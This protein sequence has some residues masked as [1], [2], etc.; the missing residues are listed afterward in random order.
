M[1]EY[2]IND[3]ICSPDDDL[4]LIILKCHQ[5]PDPPG[6]LINSSRL[7]LRPFLAVLATCY[8]VLYFQ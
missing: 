4:W 6:A 5:S 2:A 7:T 3:N 8:E 1:Y